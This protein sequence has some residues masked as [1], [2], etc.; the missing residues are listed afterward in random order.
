MF[1]HVIICWLNWQIT[2]IIPQITQYISKLS[3]L[4]ELLC[5]EFI[6]VVQQLGSGMVTSFVYGVQRKM[7]ELKLNNEKINAGQVRC[8]VTLKPFD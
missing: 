4:I 8:E 6:Q 3:F 5:A 2:F 1:L 7:G